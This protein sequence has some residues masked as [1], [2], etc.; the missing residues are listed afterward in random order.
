MPGVKYHQYREGLGQANE[1]HRIANTSLS[2]NDAVSVHTTEHPTST[3]STSPLRPH[4]RYSELPTQQL[5]QL[6][7]NI[8]VNNTLSPEQMIAFSLIE[9]SQAH[10]LFHSP[11]RIPPINT[12]SLWELDFHSISMNYRLHYDLN[13]EHELHL[14]PNFECPHGRRKSQIARDYWAAV[15]IE[16]E[17]YGFLLLEDGP[18]AA[19][20]W[21]KHWTVTFRSHAF[22]LPTIFAELRQILYGMTPIVDHALIDDVLNVEMIMQ[23]IEHGTF[24]LLNCVGWLTQLLRAYCA[25]IRDKWIQRVN[26]DFEEAAADASVSGITRGLESLFC[27]LEAMK[28]VS[29]FH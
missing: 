16:L 13:F 12:D 24:D 9:G 10:Y 23:Q 1:Q 27:I 29:S 11:Y 4:K 28:L 22:R 26:R 6:I 25:P 17:L 19:C 5:P 14:K 7:F 15:G 20:R 21:S 3:P 8:N 18:L 2:Q